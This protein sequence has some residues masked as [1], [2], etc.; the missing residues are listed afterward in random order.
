[1]EI[2]HTGPVYDV[3]DHNLVLRML[4]ASRD[5]NLVGL[6]FRRKSGSW[7]DMVQVKD[8]RYGV[9][10]A[11]GATLHSEMLIEVVGKIGDVSTQPTKWHKKDSKPIT[12]SDMHV[13]ATHL[14]TKFKKVHFTAYDESGGDQAIHGQVILSVD[15]SLHY[16]ATADLKRSDDAMLLDIS[17]DGNP[18]P[19]IHAL[20]EEGF[21]AIQ[22]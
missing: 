13:L 1:M 20:D 16:F 22:K 8:G 19:L 17:H 4:S 12:N 10:P 11:S 21:E 18:D 5:P 3:V 9:R 14:S 6:L 2:G 15:I 7:L